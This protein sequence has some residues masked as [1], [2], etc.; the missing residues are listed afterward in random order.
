MSLSREDYY[1]LMEHIKFYKKL[2]S[3]CKICPIRECT[4][5]IIHD[6][7]TN[8]EKEIR[9]IIIKDKEDKQ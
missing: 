1:M 3:F 7:L 9:E 2:K 5:C 6:S 8:L 4:R